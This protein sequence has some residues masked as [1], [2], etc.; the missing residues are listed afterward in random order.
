MSEIK[1]T[2]T[3][4]V[5]DA[6][7]AKDKPRLGV[8]RMVQAEFKRIEVDERIELDDARVLAVLD[9]M[10]KQRKD[11]AT[12]FR[13]AERPEL[14][15]QEEMESAV[16]QEFLPAALSE[17]ELEQIVSDAITETGAESARDMGKV[18]AIVKP[19]VQGRGDMG[20][21]SQLVKAKLA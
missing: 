2:I 18:M 19:Q 1:K 9:K 10:L 17:A 5:K 20:A 11:S 13:E 21:V 3:A 7:R 16:I 6:M 4:A 15:E 8:L 14:A 12:Q